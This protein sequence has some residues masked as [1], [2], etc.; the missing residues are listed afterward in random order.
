[1]RGVKFVLAWMLLWGPL[2]WGIEVKEPVFRLESSQKTVTDLLLDKQ[3]LYAA[4]GSGAV[5]VFDTAARTRVETIVL[6]GIRD[7]LGD[8]VAPK[9]YAVDKLGERL[10]IT[11]QGVSGFRDVYLYENR[12]LRKVI[13]AGEGLYITES[14]FVDA[15][16]VLL[17][18]LSSELVLYDISAQKVLYRHA[19]KER[20][21]GGSA[22]SD[23]ALDE[24]RRRVATADES[25][26]IH[27]FEIDPFRHLKVLKGQNVDNV[28]KLDYKK[29]TVITAGQDRRCAI[30]EPGG[31]AYYVGAE[32][33]IY[34]AAL[35]PSGKRG[36]YA[37]TIDNDLKVF[38]TATKGELALLKG[39][40]ATL[41]SFAFVDERHLF[42]A[43]DEREILFW[44]LGK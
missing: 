19:V 13:D 25:G 36:V 39:H 40:K 7:F 34:A 24:A 44:D 35:S 9:V 21:S 17:G 26:E 12:A 28:Y 1:M 22:F 16:R 27:L 30:Y 10:L 29:G 37:A 4:T 20:S 15:N 14:R 43:A 41:S 38:D 5:D 31:R 23:M 18:L 3:T 42:S 8:T 33:L 6:P 2:L 11:S 32:F